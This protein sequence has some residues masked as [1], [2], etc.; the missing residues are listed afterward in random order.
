M[1]FVEWLKTRCE[2]TADLASG[3]DACLKEDA[4]NSVKGVLSMDDDDWP[5]EIKKGHRKIMKM[6]AAKTQQAVRLPPLR[7]TISR[8]VRAP[9]L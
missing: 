7:P 8:L 4:F 9:Y 3:I 2:F 5:D 6:Q 1:D